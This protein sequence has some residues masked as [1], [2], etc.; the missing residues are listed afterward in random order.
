M[1]CTGG[2]SAIT[3]NLWPYALH[4]IN[5]VYDA[6]PA[7]K[8]GQTPLERFSA[9]TVRP[10]VLD[11]HPPFWSRLYSVQWPSR[12][13]FAPKQVGQMI[14]MRCLPWKVTSTGQV[15]CSCLEPPHRICLSTIPVEV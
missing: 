11:V 1:P 6:T 5:D 15:S 4:Y 2:P 12:E 9:T 8:L 14:Q 7:L 13:R 3:I 10:K